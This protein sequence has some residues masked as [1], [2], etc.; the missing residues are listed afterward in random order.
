LLRLIGVRREKKN[1]IWTRNK[2]GVE[3]Q[4]DEKRYRPGAGLTGEASLDGV[5]PAVHDEGIRAAGHR[6][7]STILSATVPL[8]KQRVPFRNEQ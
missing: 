2:F 6:H 8:D 7:V 3:T 4:N 1:Q 5:G